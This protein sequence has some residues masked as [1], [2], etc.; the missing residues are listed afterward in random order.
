MQT[1]LKLV[2]LLL[3]NSFYEDNKS[4]VVPDMFPDPLDTLYTTIVQAHDKYKKDITC[5][6][7]RALHRN[8][9]PTL[10]RAARN[11]VEELITD[12][13]LDEEEFGVE[14]AKDV[15]SEMWKKETARRVAQEALKVAEGRTESF[16]EVQHILETTGDDFMP[17]DDL[18]EE[19]TDL[20]ALIEMAEEE[21]RY[22]F[23][24]EPLATKVPGVFPGSFTMLLARPE[25]GKT[26]YLVNMVAGPGGFLDQGHNVH[27]LCNEEPSYRTMQRIVSAATGMTWAEIRENREKAYPLMDKVRKHM[28]MVYCADM[29]IERL[30]AYAKRYKPDVIIV[31]QLDK[32]NVSGSFART[33]ER[34]G[35]IYIKARQIAIRHEL[36]FFGA[37]QASADADGKTTVTYSNAADSRTAK[38]AECD[39]ILGLG[40]YAMG[41]EVSEEDHTRF[42]TVSK[43]KITGRLG[44]VVC[45]ID[46]P[47]SRFFA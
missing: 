23:N 38:A 37:T 31:D 8:Q 5:S 29:S 9:F 20:D 35:K 47:I 11:S 18:D 21:L 14:I 12:I 28:H 43:N 6:E 26:A 45:M 36:A 41:E 22:R 1:E 46:P 7:L 33:D 27:Y 3:R 39:L 15:L 34:L 44:K 19:T 25:T 42:I 13:E 17:V 24:L 32:M 2:K 40:R 10:T 4:R 30:D 16:E